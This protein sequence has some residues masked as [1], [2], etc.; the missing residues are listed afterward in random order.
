MSSVNVGNALFVSTHDV[1]TNDA[2]RLMDFVISMHS[3]EQHQS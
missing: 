1:M 2:F 3:D